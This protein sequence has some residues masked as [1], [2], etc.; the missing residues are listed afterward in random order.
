MGRRFSDVKRGAKLNTA[1]T[2]YINYLQTAGTRPSR[3]GTQG[4]RNLSVVLYIQPFTAQVAADEFLMARTT[5]ESDTKLRTIVNGVTHAAV[6]NTLGANTII[7]LPKF[8]AAR[9]VYFENS[10]RSVSVQ[11]SDITGLQYLKYAGER[12]SLPFGA[13]ADADDQMEGFLE[14]KAAILTANAA[15]AIKRVSLS[16]EYVGVEAA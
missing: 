11:S 2:N 14:A 12:F 6:T 13:N 7:T 4:A 1:L 5:P 9:V 10:T 15:A 3:I 8:K 16:R